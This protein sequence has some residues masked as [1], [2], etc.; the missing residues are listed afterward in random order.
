M[1]EGKFKTEFRHDLETL[2]PGCIILKNDPNYIQG[3]PDM[4]ILYGKRWAALE[5][6]KEGNSK[7]Q[8]N[9]PWY[10]EVMNNMSYAAFVHPGNREEILNEVEQALR[11]RRTT[12]VPRT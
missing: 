2:L 1:L 6:K 9:Q 11:P 3:I 8:P 5:F 12:R 10:V 4:L 7:R